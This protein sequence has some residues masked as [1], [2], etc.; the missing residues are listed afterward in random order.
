MFNNLLVLNNNKTTTNWNLYDIG[1]A[2]QR[3]DNHKGLCQKSRMKL[4]SYDF[5]LRKSKTKIKHYKPKDIK[6]NK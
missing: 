1:N 5:N 3:G 6:V 2:S 4:M